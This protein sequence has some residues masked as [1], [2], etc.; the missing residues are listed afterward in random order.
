M[1]LSEFAGEGRVKVIGNIPYGITGPILF[2]LIE[3]RDHVSGAYLT[4]QKEIGQRLVS[5]SHRRTY[6]ALSVVCQLVG[7]VKI[8]LNLK[9]GV[10]FTPPKVDNGYFSMVFRGRFPVR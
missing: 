5:P 10:F 1:S 2:K 4:A 8:L 7:D 9:P 6:G 3:K